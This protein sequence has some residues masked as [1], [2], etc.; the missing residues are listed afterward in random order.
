MGS[1][2]RCAKQFMDELRRVGRLV[3][4]NSA[5]RLLRCRAHEM[6]LLKHAAERRTLRE[7]NATL[8]LETCAFGWLDPNTSGSRGG[9]LFS[10]MNAVCGRVVLLGPSCRG[11]D[12]AIVIL[13]GRVSRWCFPPC[14][15]PLY[16]NSI[17]PPETLSWKTLPNALM[18]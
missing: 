5:P 17:V 14:P 11:F 1:I 6:R 4:P 9:K 7:P 2:A 3:G 10:V 8:G 12:D 18:M 16:G 15:A 13:S